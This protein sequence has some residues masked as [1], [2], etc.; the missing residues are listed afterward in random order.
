MCVSGRMNSIPLSTSFFQPSV[1]LNVFLFPPRLF[2]SVT[3]AR[4]SPFSDS[5]ADQRTMGRSSTGGEICARKIPHTLCVEVRLSKK[6]KKRSLCLR[7]LSY[8]HIEWDSRVR[9]S[10]VSILSRCTGT[11]RGPVVYFEHQISG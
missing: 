10:H 6:K 5:D 4:S 11:T 2:L 7:P 9:G 8:V 3:A 1:F